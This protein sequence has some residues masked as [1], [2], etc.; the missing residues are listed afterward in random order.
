MGGPQNPTL[1]DAF[2]LYQQGRIADAQTACDMLL[3]VQPR[4]AAALHLS[5]MLSFQSGD[6]A[7]AVERLAASVAINP[8]DPAAFNSY[9]AALVAHG[10]FETALTAAE[11]ANGLRAG[12]ASAYNNRGNALKGLGR[13]AEAAASY[14]EAIALNPNLA[15]AHNNLGAALTDLGDFD[16]SVVSID[17]AIA[18]NPA[19]ARAHANRGAALRKMKRYDQALVSFERAVALAP[20]VADFHHGRGVLLNDVKKF[21]EAAQSF[22][23]AAALRPD[24]ADTQAGL[25]FALHAAGRSAAALTA[26]DAALKLNP[27]DAE[28]WQHRGLALIN[29]QRL[30]EAVASFER[31]V[32]LKPMTGAFND[33]GIALASGGDHTRAIAAYDAALSHDAANAAAHMNR[34]ISLLQVGR[35][36]EGWTAYE[37]RWRH[38]ELKLDARGFTQPQWTGDQSLAGKTLLLHNEQGL[39]DALQF[40]RYIPLFAGTGARVVLEVQRSLAPL[41]TGGAGIA[42]VVIRG[43]ALPA[44]DFHCPLLSLPPAFATELTSIPVPGDIIRPDPAKAAT[45]AEKLGPKTRRRIGLTWSGNAAQSNDKNRSIALADFMKALPPG[46]DYVSLQKDVRESDRAALA[47]SGIRPFGDDLHDFSDTA[48]LCANVDEVVTVCTSTAHLAGALGT[49]TRVLLCFNPCWRWLLDRSDSPWYPTA[50]LY[51]Q[52]KPGAWD[53]A[54]ARVRADL[55]KSV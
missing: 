47:Q 3:R 16:A 43:E 8:N 51:R 44:F 46:F 29:L 15:D 25:G 54:L 17:R 38:P 14:M 28:T 49:P 5:G 41:F 39:G 6:A 13:S 34:G 35:L 48:A 42:Q 20:G 40:C 45:W 31:A 11:R 2:A 23:Q 24:L 36:Q 27:Q 53:N 52:D 9:T 18:L 21:D 22:A 26:F 30:S 55:E 32:A 19:L 1:Q 50:T 12:Y 4:D 10:D 37:W 7:R 33:Y